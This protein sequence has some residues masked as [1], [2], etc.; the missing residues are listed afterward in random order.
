[1][2][3]KI[4]KGI[5]YVVVGYSLWHYTALFCKSQTAGFSVARVQTPLPYDP[6]WEC[7]PPSPALQQEVQQILTQPF[8]YLGRGGQCFAFISS[9]GRYVIKFFKHRLYFP[10]N[11][12]FHIPLPL[13]LNPFR[14]ERFNKILSKI[15]RDVTSYKIAYEK[16]PGETGLL[17]LHL[18]PH[19]GFNP[20][21]TITD[22]L[23]IHHTLQLGQTAF[24]LQR[25]AI[26]L[27]TYFKQCPSRQARE[28]AMRSVLKTLATCAK[29]G[30]LDD[31][32]GI[33][34][35]MG[36]ILDR[37]IFIDVGRLKTDSSYADPAIYHQELHRTFIR[38]R[39]FLKSKYPELTPPLNETID[40]L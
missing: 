24:I 38:F 20:Q 31:D 8:R 16:I 36:F 14:N 33:H 9:D 11:L 39:S 2:F 29:K 21:V 19:E 1:M 6:R 4:G 5:L 23:G 28:R 22:M 35:N 32:P 15:D 26:P 18:Y 37:P 10:Y 7:A 25:R 13:W 12:L 27:T 40:T 34:R 3:N 30:I 17:Y